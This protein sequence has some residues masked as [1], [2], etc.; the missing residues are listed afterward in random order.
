LVGD[1]R[2]ITK[3]TIG[4]ASHAEH[5]YEQGT[6]PTGLLPADAHRLDPLHADFIDMA[7]NPLSGD[8]FQDTQVDG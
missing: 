4:G 7:G 6:L 2:L 5:N 8:Q 1:A 3:K